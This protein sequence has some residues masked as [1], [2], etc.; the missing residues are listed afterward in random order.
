MAILVIDTGFN[1]YRIVQEIS[2]MMDANLAKILKH[3]T[4][5][6][7]RGKTDQAIKEFHKAIKMNPKD[8]NLYNRLGD[9]FIRN[10]RVEE[11][12]D[13][14]RKGVDAYRKDNFARNALA[15]CKKI[16]RHDPG[17]L[18]IPYTI[19]ELLVELDE[20]SD[21]VMYFLTYVEKHL[22][23]NNEKEVLNGIEQVKKL[24]IMNSKVIK[25][26][27]EAYKILG[28]QD[29]LKQLAEEIMEGE[30][31]LEDILLPETPPP[32][33]KKE[34]AVK[35]EATAK[36]E[37]TVKKETVKPN[38]EEREVKTEERYY[39]AA[40]GVETA[41]SELRK[42]MRL[43]EV[44]VALDK[45]ISALSNE[46]KKAIAL[47]QKSVSHNLDSLQRSVK[48]LHESSDKNLK[49]LDLLLSN[50]SKALANLSKNQAS[51]TEKISG[52]LDK[53][54]DSFTGTTKDA[55]DDIKRVLSE[56][57][58]ST[59]DM[60]AKLEETKD[61]NISLVKISEDMKSLITKMNESLIKFIIAQEV[62][63]KR[64]GL[65]AKIIIGIAA[66]VTILLI[67]SILK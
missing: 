58:K 44:I 16:M 48:V 28:R 36:K 27:N 6:E 41:I 31:P 46:Q 5:L 11:A 14:Y 34:T 56:Y 20:K 30:V 54:S 49:D 7:E 67:F 65:Y 63:E 15:L 10:E 12:L 8:G 45:S 43:D 40:K 32:S 24:G 29:L 61:C 33:P 23:Q 50:L 13:T 66:A 38:R 3:A 42:A 53:M 35:R 4:E 1:L 37:P 52:S 2:I 64:Q 19:A 22:A 60:C 18:E 59:G 57:E 62:K 51:F 47:L 17:N 55:F 21:A 9:L 39:D 25:K 26:I